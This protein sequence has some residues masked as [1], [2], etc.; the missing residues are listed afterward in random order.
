MTVIVSRAEE[1][2]RREK[3]KIKEQWWICV[4]ENV[5]PTPTYLH[6]FSLGGH[7]SFSNLFLLCWFLSPFRR[8][9]VLFPPP[10]RLWPET[11]VAEVVGRSNG[12]FHLHMCS[13]FSRTGFQRN[14]VIFWDTFSLAD[15]KKK[16][17][18]S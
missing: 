16:K 11:N 9:T 4:Q 8:R 18:K 12:I 1:K 2:K 5:V 14:P 10:L 3:E 15:L 7:C 17:K 6:A 13:A